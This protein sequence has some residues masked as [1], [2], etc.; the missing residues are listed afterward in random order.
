MI[1]R[2][3]ICAVA[4]LAT[5]GA[6]HSTPAILFS[7]KCAGSAYYDLSVLPSGSYKTEAQKVSPFGFNVRI[8]NLE[9]FRVYLH[10]FM[11][12]S[13]ENKLDS[14][15]GFGGSGL[16][17]YKNELLSFDDVRGVPMDGL[18]RAI[19]PY[20]QTINIQQDKSGI[21]AIDASVMPSQLALRPFLFSL[22]RGS[23]SWKFSITQQ[24]LMTGKEA[25]DLTIFA[26]GQPYARTFNA[27]TISTVMT[28]NCYEP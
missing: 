4:V 10:Q 21:E 14:F 7:W 17:T 6:A 16:K 22:H 5:L 20:G 26:A 23:H 28:G 3:L 13:K 27:D 1:S 24:L 11:T 2:I 15:D 9:Q 12:G 25:R 18:D 8:V 19:S